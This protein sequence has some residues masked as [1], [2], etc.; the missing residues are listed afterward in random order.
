MDDDT[1]SSRDR[2]ELLKLLELLILIDSTYALLIWLKIVFRSRLFSIR[3][4]FFVVLCKLELFGKYWE[5]L[6]SNYIFNNRISE[7]GNFVKFAWINKGKFNFNILRGIKIIISKF[8][9]TLFYFFSRDK[10]KKM[11]DRWSLFLQPI[12]NFN[13][14]VFKIWKIFIVFTWN[15]WSVLWNLLLYDETTSERD[16]PWNYSS[17]ECLSWVDIKITRL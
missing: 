14:F 16:K 1:S 11:I 5:C 3:E 7:F 4:N 10:E 13:D 9:F 12:E 17:Y 15:V 2:I 6:L 8:L